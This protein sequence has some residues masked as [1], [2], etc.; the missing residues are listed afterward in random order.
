M[1]RL[2]LR[3]SLAHAAHGLLGGVVGVIAGVAF[4]ITSFSADN[5]LFGCLSVLVGVMGFGFTLFFIDRMM[6]RSVQVLIDTNG[7]QDHRRERGLI[8]WS[9]VQEL[10][11]R[12]EQPRKNVQLAYL[13]CVP[14]SGETIE[15]EITLFDQ[16]P[17]S[18]FEQAVQIMH[19][20]ASRLSQTEPKPPSPKP[21]A[22]QPGSEMDKAAKK[23]RWKQ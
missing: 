20:A 8:C 4:S 14:R 6:N 3:Y 1:E 2:E 5:I 15:I 12:F 13:V 23:H 16:P 22:P 18:I 11:L 17:K 10:R 21:S 19:Q 9:S 7:I